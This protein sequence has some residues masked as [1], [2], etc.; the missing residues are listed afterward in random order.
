MGPIAMG[1][2]GIN[3]R[4]F[5]WLNAAGAFIWAATFSCLGYGFGRALNVLLDDLHRLERHI[6]TVIAV[7]GAAAW[8]IYQL[9]QRRRSRPDKTA[10]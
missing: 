2:S 9:V 5:T 1:M 8:V 4:R 3:M 6:M 7:A 10:D